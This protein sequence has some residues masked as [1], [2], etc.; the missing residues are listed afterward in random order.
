MNRI[1]MCTADNRVEL[2]PYGV[3]PPG[4]GQIQIRSAVTLVSPGTERAL[5]KGMENA[6]REHPFSLG[7]S[8]AGVVE[9]VGDDQGDFRPGERVAAFC[10]PHC[11]L[12][13]VDSR[14]CLKIPDRVSFEKAAFLALGVIALAGVRKARLE[15]GEAALVYGQGPVGLL[16]LMLLK[17]AGAAPVIGCDIDTWRLE[18]ASELGADYVLEPAGEGLEER[19]AALCGER[20]EVVIE[21]TGVPTALQDAF[22]AARPFGRVVLLGCPRGES[23]INFYTHVQQPAVTIIPAHVMG[24]PEGQSRPGYWTWED[25]AAAFMKLLELDR[26]DPLPLITHRVDYSKIESVYDM[27]IRGEEHMLIPLINWS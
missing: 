18:R 5:L 13:N 7:Y 16:A 8:V 22:R 12:G 11:S 25:D 24:N 26:L 23:R 21:S 15:L 17:L 6:K 20:P 2:Q 27:L 19:L 1:V 3:E 4:P 14:F 9:Q 10:L